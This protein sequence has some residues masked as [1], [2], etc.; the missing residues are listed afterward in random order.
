MS[1]II[2]GITLTAGKPSKAGAVIL[3]FFD[4][5]A[6]GIRLAGCA[7]VRTRRTGLTIWEPKMEAAES[8]RRSVVI[9]DPTLKRDITEAARD[10]YC[11]LGGVGAERD[12]EPSAATE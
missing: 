8:V 2:T 12:P 9:V 4:C 1:V 5:V 10:I 6:V 3:C 11:R 7:L